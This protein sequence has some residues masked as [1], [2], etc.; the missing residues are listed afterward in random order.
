MKTQSHEQ[1]RS[2]PAAALTPARRT[3]QRKCACGGTPGPD[4]ECAACR[5]KRLAMQSH[6]TTESPRGHD[7]G[8]VGIYSDR[9]AVQAPGAPV[10]KFEDCPA[11]WRKK[12]NDALAVGRPWVANVITG[13]SNLPNPIPAPVAAL[14]NKHFHTT[15]RSDIAEIVKHYTQI[16]SAINHSIDFE[17]ETECD[18]S[19]AAYV[20]SIWTDL[21][22]CPIWYNNLDMK[23]K[24]NTII[25]ELAHDAAGRD[26]EAYIWQAKYQTLSVED[27]IDNAD[28]YSNFAQD[29]S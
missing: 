7:F 18:D 22:L 16:N 13:L 9:K 20:Y 8:R 21:H 10:N 28:S 3:L 26:D 4:G 23:G 14:L 1:K 6:S 29:A 19:V 27:A 24:A 15:N 17:C 25:H 5:R 2:A 12:A 11:D